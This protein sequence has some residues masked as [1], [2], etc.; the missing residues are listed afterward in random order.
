MKKILGWIVSGVM[1]VYGVIMTLAYIGSQAQ[2]KDEQEEKRKIVERHERAIEKVG[3]EEI[4]DLDTYHA[5]QLALCQ[6][7]SDAKSKDEFDEMIEEH[8]I[9]GVLFK[10]LMNVEFHCYKSN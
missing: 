6:R 5:K 9:R 10:T 8:D 2:L 7:L 3:K 1:F 4:C